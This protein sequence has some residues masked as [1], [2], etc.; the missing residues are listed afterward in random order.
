MC[1]ISFGVGGFL[2]IGYMKNKQTNAYDCVGRTA[3][4]TKLQL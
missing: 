4:D 3:V 1:G 2:K